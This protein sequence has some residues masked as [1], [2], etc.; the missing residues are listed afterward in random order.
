MADA[1]RFAE[2]ARK[3][4]WRRRKR[5]S[6]WRIRVEIGIDLIIALRRTGLL[7][8][9]LDPISIAQAV[10]WALRDWASAQ[11]KLAAFDRNV[12]SGTLSAVVPG[13][14]SLQYDTNFQPGATG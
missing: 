4:D 2:A 7:L 12:P 11:R 1:K 8:D 10:V 3:R 13:P 5:L 9:E 6:S 14:T